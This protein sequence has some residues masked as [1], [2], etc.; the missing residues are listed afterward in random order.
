MV[1]ACRYLDHQLSEPIK[2]LFDP[3]MPDN[4][5]SLIKGDHTRRIKKAMPTTGGLMKFVAVT[6]RCLGCKA[7]ISDKQA[8]EDGAALCGNCKPRE[9]EIYLNKLATLQ[10]CEKLFWQTQVQCQRI[11][12]ENF[13][14]VLGIA[15][16]SQIYYL[17]KKAK[18]DLKEAR[19]TLARFDVTV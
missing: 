19:E 5:E 4:V 10:Q 2:R 1:L 17:M 18:K 8:A 3:I 6:Q 14:D 13:K 9:A 7:A 11:T 16:D 15:R 12:G